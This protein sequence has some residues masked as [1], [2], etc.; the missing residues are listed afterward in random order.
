[1]NTKNNKIEA[2]KTPAPQLQEVKLQ[3]ILLA[4]ITAETPTK[5][6]LELLKLEDS[7]PSY[8]FDS[9]GHRIENLNFVK[10]NPEDLPVRLWKFSSKRDLER[11]LETD[12]LSDI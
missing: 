12:Y 4:E 10:L 2:V 7:W 9:S 11:E 6:I 3:G 5:E 1:M 8:W